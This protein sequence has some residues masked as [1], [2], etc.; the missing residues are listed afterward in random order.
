MFHRGWLFC[1]GETGGHQLLERQAGP[2][3]GRLQASPLSSWA[4]SYSWSPHWPP[5]RNASADVAPKT[6]SWTA[7]TLLHPSTR[8]VFRGWSLWKVIH[9]ARARQMPPQAP[10][11]REQPHQLAHTSL[12]FHVHAGIKVSVPTHRTLLGFSV[13]LHLTNNVGDTDMWVILALPSVDM[14]QASIC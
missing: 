11:A 2:V 1:V 13:G 12:T 10:E 6:T 3:G 5:V 8:W 9:R 4:P 7:F 14:A